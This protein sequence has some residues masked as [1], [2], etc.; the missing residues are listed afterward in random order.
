MC[1]AHA[2]EASFISY[3]EDKAT[4]R[5]YD[6]AKRGESCI[7]NPHKFDYYEGKAWLHGWRCFHTGL[8]PYAMEKKQIKETP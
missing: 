3:L 6:A 2:G 1:Q 8:V 4:I 7:T 5:G